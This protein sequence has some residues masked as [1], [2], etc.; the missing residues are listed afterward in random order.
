MCYRRTCM[1][2]GRP[3]YSGCGR[4]IEVV[5]GDVP[6][7]ERCPGHKEDEDEESP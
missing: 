2:C 7:E 1:K 3:T 5:L 6:P 4:H